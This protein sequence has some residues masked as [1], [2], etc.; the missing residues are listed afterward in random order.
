MG[1]T[2]S[3]YIQ[4][5]IQPWAEYFLDWKVQRYMTKLKPEDLREWE[6]YD[7]EGVALKQDNLPSTMEE[8]KTLEIR[9]DDVFI[10]TYTKA[11][12]TWTQE[13]MSCVLHDG[14]L[15][16]VNKRHTMKRVPFLEM[17]TGGTVHSDCPRTHRMIGWMPRSSPR[18]IKSHLPGQLLPP[19][20]WEKKVKIV[21]VIRNPKDVAVSYFHHTRLLCPHLDIS[22]DYFFE[23]FH[24]GDIGYGKWWEHYLYFWERR[25]EDHILLLRFEDMKKD[26]RGTVKQISEFLGKSFS[27]DIIDAI[28]DHCTFANMKK[29]P[30]TNPDVLIQQIVGKREGV[31]FMR[32]GVVGDSKTQLSESQAEAIDALCKEKLT[33]VGLTFD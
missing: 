23:K 19:Q 26:L 15:D 16:E 11:G 8:L 12:T 6:V 7:Y 2:V 33:V 32:K 29:N 13:I 3:G 18:L 9:Q 4:P 5:W 14:N 28:T 1:Q 22:W 21:Y 24:S 10:V 30:M 25:N 20:V 27:D 31:S 17:N